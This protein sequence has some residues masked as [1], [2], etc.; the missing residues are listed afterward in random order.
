VGRVS[1]VSQ[2]YLGAV[3]AGKSTRAKLM[4]TCLFICV[5]EVIALPT[6][7]GKS[8]STQ[9]KSARVEKWLF[10]FTGENPSTTE[11]VP[12]HFSKTINH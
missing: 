4:E 12:L 7:K 5:P 9:G 2:N 6:R 3:T 10:L 1:L 11:S 8:L